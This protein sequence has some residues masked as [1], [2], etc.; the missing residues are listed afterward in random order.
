[1]VFYYGIPWEPEVHQI[2]AK[3]EK[4]KW[5]W[6]FS[7]SHELA[8]ARRVHIRG[9]RV[10]CK[11]MM[12]FVKGEKKRLVTNNDIKDFIPSKKPDKNKTSLGPESSRGG[13]L[14]SRT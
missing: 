4:L 6:R 11:P 2:F 3:Y 7:V 10:H 8:Q 12:W 9:V 13:I 5:W 14:S 1:M